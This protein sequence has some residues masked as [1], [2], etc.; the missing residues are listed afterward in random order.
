MNATQ[1]STRRDRREAAQREKE[2]IS[3]WH[4]GRFGTYLWSELTPQEQRNHMAALARNQY[5]QLFGVY[6]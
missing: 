6:E 3:T 5:V 2:T 1:N 4:N